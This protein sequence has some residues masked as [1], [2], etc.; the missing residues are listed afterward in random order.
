MKIL[1]IAIL[2]LMVMSVVP[3]AVA[4]RPAPMG[5][6]V[7]PSFTIDNSKPDDSDDTP[8]VGGGGSS[9][10]GGLIEPSRSEE[11]LENESTQGSGKVVRTTL[12]SQYIASVTPTFKIWKV[13]KIVSDD[14]DAENLIKNLSDKITQVF[15]HLPRAEQKRILDMTQEQAEEQLGNYE[16]MAVNK[17]L[18]YKV[19]VIPVPVLLQAR[20]NVQDAK[21]EYEQ[22]KDELDDEKEKF[23]NA[24]LGKD[25]K[26]ATEHAKRY[27]L[28]T[29]DLVIKA[30]ERVQHSVESSEDLS[31]ENAQEI[32]DE[33]Q[34]EID[35]MTEAKQT[36]E[37]AESK[38]EVQ[39]A[40]KV[41]LQAWRQTRIRIKRHVT[42]LIHAR[43]GEIIKRSE[44]LE[45]KLDCTLQSLEEQGVDIS[46]YDDMVSNFSLDVDAAKQK[47]RLAKQY[48]DQAKALK[49]DNPS[50]DDLAE[51]EQLID[52]AKALIDEAKDY[53]EL[54]HEI[55][56]DLVR[57]IKAD[58]YDLTECQ[59]P[60]LEEDE[61]Y[62]VVEKDDN[63]E[64]DEFCGI[65]SN[66]ACGSDDDCRTGGCSGQLCESKKEGPIPNA[67]CPM[68]ECY[69]ATKYGLECGCVEG[70]CQWA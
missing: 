28:K 24:K 3:L 48:L 7:S 64:E 58:G 52:D 32:L 55:L 46:E 21:K 66:D 12:L 17:S 35:S 41:I 23:E 45:S 69:N 20:E 40:G 30:L 67:I 2:V 53:L 36:I 33:I 4:E 57:S 15:L 49:A 16:L 60:G 25:D 51:A 54:A 38:D 14:P 26:Q 10:G 61:V 42:R 47:F 56:K 63:E 31:E 34:E 59:D 70:E 11:S 44:H 50:E 6:S 13:N 39:D 29:V 1:T 65:S 62:D 5:T 19:R 68:K 22:I 37:D 27:M 18:L 9:G 43:L 8:S